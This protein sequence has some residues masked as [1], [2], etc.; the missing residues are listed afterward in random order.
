MAVVLA[1]APSLGG[2]GAN[3]RNVVE[4]DMRFEHCYRLDE[5][6]ATPL[7]SKRAC[8]REWSDRYTRGQDRSRIRYA[9][10]R[11]VVLDDASRGVTLQSTSPATD[12]TQGPTPT[13]AYVVPPAVAPRPSAEPEAIAPRRAIEACTDACT[14]TFRTCS[15]ECSGADACGG[16][17]E[18][19]Y[20]GCLKGCL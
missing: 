20:R 11:L 1:A 17:C 7:D 14:R 6:P 5:D 8:W 19:R 12:A 2:C 9:R 3:M 15:Q 13:S 18:D 4:S 10:D 16:Y